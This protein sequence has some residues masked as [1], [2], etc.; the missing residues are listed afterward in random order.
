MRDTNHICAISC[1]NVVC[2]FSGCANN[3]GCAMF[4]KLLR[5]LQNIAR[6]ANPLSCQIR[7][8]AIK[9]RAMIRHRYTP[10][11]LVLNIFSP[12]RHRGHRERTKIRKMG[13]CEPFALL[14]LCGES[15][16]VAKNLDTFPIA[17]VRITST[18]I[19]LW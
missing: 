10:S 6:I 18:L 9:C 14:C 2:I 16:N 11:T 17:C 7:C 15:E 8:I 13:L 1:A 5:K 12:Q 3:K 19:M 4:C